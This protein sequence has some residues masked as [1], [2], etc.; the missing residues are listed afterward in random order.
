MKALIEPDILHYLAGFGGLGSA[1]RGDVRPHMWASVDH[2]R[3][4]AWPATAPEVSPGRPVAVAVPRA[5]VRS[6][7]A[8]YQLRDALRR[9]LLQRRDGMRVGIEGDRDI[10][11]AEPLGD[12]LGVDAGL[13]GQGG[14]GMA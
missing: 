7:L 14:V 13:Q 12:D 4:P 9:L 6:A 11:V 10:G 3:G 2:F 8:A 1:S 5:P